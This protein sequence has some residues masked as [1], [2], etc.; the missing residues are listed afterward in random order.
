MA[1]ISRSLV[2]D[3]DGSAPLLVKLQELAS[4]GRLAALAQAMHEYLSVVPAARPYVIRQ[5]GGIVS[6]RYLA[7]HLKLDTGQI[8]RWLHRHE[9]LYGRLIDV[10]EPASFQVAMELAALLVEL[11]A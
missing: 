11:G 2:G 10:A 6:N 7:G 1:A 3:P 8:A 5:L 4:A 9:K